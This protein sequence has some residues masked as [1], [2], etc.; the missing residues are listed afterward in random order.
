MAFL[1]IGPISLDIVQDSP[2]EDAAFEVGSSSRAMDGLLQSGVRGVK[3]RWSCSTL[4]LSEAEVE[5]LLS[6]VEPGSFATCTGTIFGGETP[7]TLDCL[8]TVESEDLEEATDTPEG[9]RR[10]LNLVLYEA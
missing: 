5:A 6:V 4:P 10:V 8:L 9:Y 1:Q 7:R 3:R 2:T